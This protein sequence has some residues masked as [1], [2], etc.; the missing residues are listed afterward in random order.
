[1]HPFFCAK[2]PMA[3]TKSNIQGESLDFNTKI[4][5]YYHKKHK[6]MEPIST[7]AIATVV[8]YLAK[9]L[10][11]NKSIQTF[12]SDF[13]A[14]TVNWIRPIFL[15]GEAPKEVLKNLQEAPDDDL[16]QTDV[17]TAIQRAV[18]NNP[19]AEK[20]L[21][22]MAEIIR[23]KTGETNN[24]GNI[25]TITGDGNIGVQGISGSSINI[26]TPPTQKP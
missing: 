8:G 1:M 13:T 3:L 21:A 9:T 6:T 17:R 10:K 23:K 12:F 19:D 15:E 18:R 2:T 26:G 16:N 24:S 14:A 11:D 5:L 20:M 25:M 22:E 4:F 7:A